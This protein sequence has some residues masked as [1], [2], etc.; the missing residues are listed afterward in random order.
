MLGAE[1]SKLE[2]T[3]ELLK[4]QVDKLVPPKGAE[5]KLKKADELLRQENFEALQ[6]C[7]FNAKAIK[8]ALDEYDNN[9]NLAAARLGQDAP[10]AK[11]AKPAAAAGASS[12]AADPAAAD[13]AAPDL[14]A[15]DLAAPAA[16]ASL[17]NRREGKRKASADKVPP[18]ALK[19]V[20]DMGFE[21]DAAK[22]ALEMYGN[23]VGRAA[24]YLSSHPMGTRDPRRPRE[25]EV[26]ARRPRQGEPASPPPPF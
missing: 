15:P 1:P 19:D 10:P 24:N 18:Q 26:P 20:C 11:K 8:V 21:I 22:A 12:A 5:E 23:D 17:Q 14:A 4:I 3:V 6:K 13:L 16:T 2:R 25:G 7:G 9:L